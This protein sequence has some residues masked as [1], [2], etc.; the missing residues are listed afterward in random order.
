MPQYLGS[1]GTN[2]TTSSLMVTTT[3]SGDSPVMMIAS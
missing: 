3:G 1:A 2:S